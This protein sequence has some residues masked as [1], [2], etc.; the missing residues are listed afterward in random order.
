MNI[1]KN[2]YFIVRRIES[3]HLININ[4]KSDIALHTTLSRD[5]VRVDNLKF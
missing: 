2:Y 4:I 5:N 3:N 1:F